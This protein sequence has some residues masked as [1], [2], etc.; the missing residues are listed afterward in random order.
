MGNN[1]HAA[2]GALSPS[3]EGFALSDDCQVKTP[4]VARTVGGGTWLGTDRSVQILHR[5]RSRRDAAGA[6]QRHA[7]L[8]YCSR[9]A[10]RT[11][12]ASYD[13]PTRRGS[14]GTMFSRAERSHCPSCPSTI[15]WYAFQDQTDP[16]SALTQTW[17]PLSR[18][19]T[20]ASLQ[21]TGSSL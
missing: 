19:G 4:P 3:A 9:P 21:R 20:L 12:A 16:S 11:T 8:S 10:S 5:G 14:N 15:C 1:K 18:L 17:W 2:L 13:L 6:L 7:S